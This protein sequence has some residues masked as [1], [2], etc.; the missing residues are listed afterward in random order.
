MAVTDQRGAFALEVVETLAGAGFEAVWAGGCV[1]DL[2]L[3]RTPEDY[4]IATDA[5]PDR[6]LEVF[7]RAR[8]K[9]V[10]AAFGVV[11]VHGRGDQSPIEV[12][13]FRTEEGYH[14]GRHPEV[15]RFATRQEDARRRDFTINGM[16]MDPRTGEV[17]D[18]VGGREDLERRVLRAIGDPES[19]F[20]EDKLR[21]LRAVRFASSLSFSLD[22]ATARAI[23]DHAGEISVVSVERVAGEWR[24]MLNECHRG[25]AVRLAADTGLLAAIFPEIPA[26]EQDEVVGRVNALPAD[27]GFPL[28]LAVML[29]E[30]PEARSICDRLKLS[31]RETDEVAWLVA[32][33]NGLAR[34]DSQ[35]RS[36]LFPLLS[37][38]LAD[39]LLELVE[40][41]SRSAERSSADVAWCRDLIGRVTRAELDPPAFLSGDDLIADGLSPGP[42]FKTLLDSVRAAQLDGELGSRDEAMAL[43]HRLRRKLEND[44]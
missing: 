16:F 28:A 5:H 30:V 33:R 23:A 18:D 43:A 44:E 42:L 10:G 27:A 17:F 21:M 31:N 41:V 15:V 20:N 13:T 26:N 6:V 8:T 4:D 37:H 39:Q 36:R 32:S 11:L 14:D 38:P 1:R 25:Q 2:L 35:K 40:A 24:R 3:E 29:L 12:A 34:A 7:G 9:T 22:P 19:R